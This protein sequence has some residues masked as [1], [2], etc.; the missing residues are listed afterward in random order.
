MAGNDTKVVV[1]TTAVSASGWASWN[2]SRYGDWTACVGDWP[3]LLP[4]RVKIFDHELVHR[5]FRESI[6]YPSDTYLVL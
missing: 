3:R 6:I 1:L 5:M 2:L 4:V